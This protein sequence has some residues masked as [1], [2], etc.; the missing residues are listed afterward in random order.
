MFHILKN[1]LLFRKKM[2]DSHKLLNIHTI[3]SRWVNIRKSRSIQ[4]WRKETIISRV[5]Y[6]YIMEIF[7]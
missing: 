7:L 3:F 5:I 4:K 2:E 1:D 6:Y